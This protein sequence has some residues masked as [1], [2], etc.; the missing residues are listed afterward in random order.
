VLDLEAMLAAGLEPGF[1]AL[2]GDAPTVQRSPWADFQANGA[3]ALARRLNRP[4]AEVAAEILARAELAG[5]ATAEV[6][7]PGFLNLT[8]APAVL[9]RLLTAMAADERLGV[10]LTRDPLRI[11]VDYCGPNVA[12]EMHVGHLRSTIIG[13]SLVRLLRWA[14]HD[15]VL[16]SHL[17]DWGTPF[18]M[19]LEWLVE[20]GGDDYSIADLDAFYKQAR[21]RFD[22]DP[23]FVTRSRQRVVALQSGDPESRRLWRILVATS[24]RYFEA[25]NAKL[26]VELSPS[27]FVGESFYNKQLEPLMSELD[28]LGLLST[29]DGAE[30]VY[31]PGFSGRDGEPFGFIVRKSDGGFG[32]QATDLAALRYR[33]RD[34]RADRVIYVLGAPQQQYLAMVFAV[35]RAAGWLTDVDQAVHKPFGSILGEDGRMLRSRAGRSVKLAE[36]LDE[37]VAAAAALVAQTRPDLDPAEQTAIA[38]AVG[39]GSIKYADLSA[40]MIKDYRYDAARMI[41]FTGDTAGYLQMAHARAVSILRA[42]AGPGPIHVTEPAERELALALLAFPAVVAEVLGALEP[43]R[44][45]GAVRRVAVAFTGFYESCPVRRAQP[46]VQASRASLCDLTARV[47][48]RGLNLLGIDAPPRM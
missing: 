36:L 23:A 20:I 9:D 37:A 48:A 4:P 1:L 26:H 38:D 13:D 19:L 41:S 46:P 2:G 34:L 47:L 11:V 6:S 25:V 7:G 35:A 12:K 42:A 24:A 10:P 43:H 17:G 44:L 40:D 32:Y 3:L 21:H 8:V 5:L 18:G 16:I 29:S 15:V 27:D 14:G 45:A 22:T 39:I 30:V 28:G 33:R 31:P